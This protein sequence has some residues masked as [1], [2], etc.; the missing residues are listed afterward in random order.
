MAKTR[1]R[2]AELSEPLNIRV[3]PSVRSLI[4]RAAALVKQN[5]TDFMLEASEQRAQRVLLDRVVFSV[6]AEVYAEFVEQL[7]A[8]AKPN[9]RLRHTMTAKAP[10]DAA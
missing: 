2:D 10:W 9:D 4:D 5:R 3:K 1:R 8:P 6:S 7:D